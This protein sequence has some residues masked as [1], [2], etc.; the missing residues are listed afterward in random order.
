M[1]GM[2]GTPSRQPAMASI[3]KSV[4]L[5]CD[6]PEMVCMKDSNSLAHVTFI[7]IN[8]FYKGPWS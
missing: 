4:N 7:D 1:D 5:I 2:G 6:F 8:L 3:N